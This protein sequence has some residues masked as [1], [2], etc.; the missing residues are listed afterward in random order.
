MMSD[1]GSGILLHLT[2]LPSAY[3]IGDIGPAAYRFADF[4]AESGQSYWQILPL[5]PT[6]T[7]QGNSPY[8]S[9]SAFACNPLLVSPDLM[10]EQG[11]LPRA[12]AEHLPRLPQDRVDYPAAIELKTRLLDAAYEHFSRTQDR[13]EFDGFCSQNSHWLE[14]FVL[15]TVLKRRFEGRVWSE[16][17]VELRD[18]HP[19]AMTAARTE[20]AGEI[21]KQRF[22]Q[23]LFYKQWFALKE[24]CNQKGI[25]IIGDIPIYVSYDSADAWSDPQIF[26]LDD[27]KQLIYMAGVPPDYF[28]R[29][30]Q[31]WGNPVYNWDV[32]KGT[33]FKWWL[34]R[35]EHTLSLYD[36]VRIDHLRGLVAYWEVP[37]G[38]KTAI[39]GRWVEVPS[40]AFFDTMLGR[41]PDFPIIAEDLGVI[42]P[43]VREL[44]NHYG[45]PGMKVLL[46]AFN[47]DNP[48]HPYLPHT[49]EPNCVV[50]TGTHD[51]DTVRGWYEH[52]A[53][54]EDRARLARYVGHEVDADSANRE[55][56]K[57]A[58]E[59]V[60][61]RAILP[62]QDVLGL[63]SEAR[64]N[65]PATLNGNWAW[66]L[67]PDQPTPDITQRLR[68]M[69]EI[70]GRA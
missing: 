8:S 5:M 41:F 53:R 20:L 69:T 58:M 12:D 47:E 13:G 65:T 34:R 32:C 22:I 66:R 46:F 16:W 48:E 3:G 49:Y 68:E 17:P 10:V 40:R 6:I 67:L 59:S 63:G 33:G 42:T 14:D 31:L 29:T 25:Q 37:A 52:G 9:T 60:A 15:F 26:K 56:L 35:M 61:E 28:S 57:L 38:E 39:K 24:Y 30:G 43:D 44:M 4:L 54:P 45:F 50:Y 18:R 62:M 2:S 51:N 55:F 23:F 36:I 11:Y 70:Y 19:D 1:R 7:I 27:S 21:D 64:M